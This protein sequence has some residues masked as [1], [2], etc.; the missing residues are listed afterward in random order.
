[1]P[2][3]RTL[4]ELRADLAV[5]LGF[6]SAGAN[7][8]SLVPILNSMLYAS[9]TW[10][11]WE[12][13]WRSLRVHVTK[14]LGASQIYLDFPT[15]IHPDRIQ[16]ISRKF[17]DVWSPPLERGIPAELYTT[18]DEEGPPARWDL[19]GASGAL[20][21]EFWPQ[22]DAIYPIRIFGVAP[23]G[24][25]TQDGHRTTLDSELVFTHALMTAKAHYKHPDAQI[26][27]DLFAGLLAG[28]KARNW[29]K[30][31]FSPHERPPPIPKP[32]VVGRI[33]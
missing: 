22:S 11:Y 9:Q 18:Q 31:V 17:S 24:D 1:M 26:Y 6:G 30:R 19:N 10:L 12:F 27:A 21:I 16:W 20:Q 32:L 14:T 13:D 29:T 4:G 5:R 15:E 28:Q 2:L 25:F 8:G 33:S 23:L 3:N 7:L